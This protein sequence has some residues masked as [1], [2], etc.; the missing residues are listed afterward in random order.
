[1][2]RLIDGII[3]RK[4]KIALTAFAIVEEIRRTMPEVR[5]YQLQKIQTILE[6]HIGKLM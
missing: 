5:P 4:T 3:G 6:K 1:M 2:R